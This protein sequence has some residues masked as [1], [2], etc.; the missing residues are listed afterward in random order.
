MTGFKSDPKT[1]VSTQW[2]SEH[3]D[4]PDLRILDGSWYLP[5]VRRNP[6][7]EYEK[8]HIPGAR[9]FDIDDLADDTSDVPHMA[10]SAEKFASRMRR[11]G[12]GDGHQIVVYDGVGVNSAARVWWLFRF[13]GHESVAVLDGGLPKWCSEGRSIEDLPPQP[14][15][16]HITVRIQNH[17][18]RNLTQVSDASAEGSSEIVDAR[19]TGRFRG[20]D[21]EPRENL[22]SGHIPGSRNVPFPT[23]I[24]SD[25]TMKD[26][27]EL[28]A[29]FT[30]GKCDLTKPV[31]TT[32][33]SG[34]TACILALA[35]ERIGHHNWAIYDGSWAEW[36]ACSSVKI[37]TGEV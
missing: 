31:I 24:N 36:G 17:L 2:L 25:G 9:F 29:A 12:L 35:L 26:N 32:C 3:L 37:S 16:R 14:S 30:T 11:M 33:G 15:E 18:I 34:I 27:E 21:L 10:P 20:H 5:S 7:T 19:P 4:D 6:R 22:P 1:L 13:M 23:L 28:R 8:G